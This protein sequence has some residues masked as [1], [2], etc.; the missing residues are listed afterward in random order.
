MRPEL[1]KNKLFLV[2]RGALEGRLEPLYY[3][4]TIVEL[5]NK[6]RTISSRKLKDYIVKLS[7]GATPS[8]KEEEKFY[9]DSDNGIPFIRVQ[10]LCTTN[11][12]LLEDLK[13][14]NVETHNN[15]LYR[16]QVHEHDLLVKITGVGRMAISSVAPS[17]FI[18]NTNQHLVVIRT[19]DKLTSE[20]LATF[21]NTDIGEKI[22]SRRSTGATRPALDY[23][24]LKSIPIVF[25]PETIE[26]MKNAVLAKR[27][28]EAEAKQMLA[29]IDSYLLEQLGIVLPEKIEPKKIFCTHFKDVQG[30]R[31]DPFYHKVE[32][33]I[34]EKALKNGKY[35]V[36]I[37][38]SLIKDLKNGVEIRTY[39]ETGFRYLRVTDLDKHNI[40]NA[41]IRL[42]DVDKIPEKIKL[43]KDCILIARSGSLGL[44]SV[45]HDDLLNSILSSHI[46][47]IELEKDLIFP[48]YLEIFLRSILGQKQFFRNNNGGVVPEINQGALK[49]IQI[50]V[51]PLEI[52]NAIA[53]H[54]SEI[55]RRAQQLEQEAIEIVE[56]AKK[57]VEKMILG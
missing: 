34:L 23:T 48:E 44:V 4:P 42:V 5:E 27:S 7:S 13:Y 11:E 53:A 8:V 25:K 37:F 21:L 15:Y 29:G 6:I 52:Q 32:F 16:S 30:K 56:A 36:V 41:D 51:P 31:F 12:L 47:K 50:P 22:A 2:Q 10:N 33:D 18:G 14:I 28:K 55:R 26:I 45:V 40:N 20:T 3:I 49:S 57:E 24:A 54:I 38:K 17:N 19:K 35:E 43:N 39:S 9:S 46:F 1:N